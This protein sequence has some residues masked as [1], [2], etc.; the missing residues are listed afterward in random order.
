MFAFAIISLFNAANALALTT[1]KGSEAQNYL[2]NNKQHLSSGKYTFDILG[3]SH[4]DSMHGRFSDGVVFNADGGKF[5]FPRRKDGDYI[6]VID[7]ANGREEESLSEEAWSKK[8]Q[9][10]LS[11]DNRIPYV[12]LDDTKKELAIVYVG[13]STKVNA[14]MNDENLLEISIAVEG[15][16]SSHH[17][18]KGML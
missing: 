18:R 4:R 1:L 9:N 8:I 11:D 2:G 3:R 17:F 16:Q 6:I 14:K 10:A 7:A 12:F 13:S 15:A 5:H